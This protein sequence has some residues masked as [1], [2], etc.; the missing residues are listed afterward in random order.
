MTKY[1]IGDVVSANGWPAVILE[2]N[3][4]ETPNTAV[5]CAVFGWEVDYGSVYLKDITPSEFK[6]EFFKV[7]PE[8]QERFAAVVEEQRKIGEKKRKAAAARAA[9]KQAKAQ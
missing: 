5:L 4:S 2:A 3:R 9:K 1:Q 8:R 6:V 7:T